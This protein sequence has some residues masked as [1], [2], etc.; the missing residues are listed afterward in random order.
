MSLAAAATAAEMAWSMDEASGTRASS[1]GSH[2]LSDNNTVGSATGQFN[3]AALFVAASSEYL[4]RASGSDVTVGDE[5]ASWSLWFKTPSSFP[6]SNQVLLTRQAG[7]GVN[8]YNLVFQSAFTRLLFS[9]GIAQ[10]VSSV[11]LSTNTW[12]F[13]SFGHDSVNNLVFLRISGHTTDTTSDSGFD[14]FLPI[15]APLRVGTDQFSQFLDGAIDDLVFM[16]GYV[17]TDADHDDAYASGTGV[18]FSSWAGGGVTVTPDV[19]FL[20]L[21]T[22]A[23]VVS[24]PALATPG[25]VSLTL[26]AFAP[27]VSTPTTATPGLAT[28]TLALLAPAVAT[29][30]VVTPGMASL[31]LSAFAPDITVGGNIT[32]VPFKTSL[33]L[34]GRQPALLVNGVPVDTPSDFARNHPSIPPMEGELGRRLQRFSEMV[35]DRFNSL[36]RLGLIRF[37]SPGHWDLAANLHALADL[38]GAADKLAYFT[39]LGTMALTTLTAFGRSLIGAADAAT[40]RGLI[41]AG[42]GSGTVTSITLTQP[43]AG[44][45]ITGSGVAIITT[46]TPTFALANDLA[47]LEALSGTDTIYYR[48][49]VSTWSAVNVSTGLSFTSGTLTAT[50]GGGT[51][52]TTGSP[53]SG[54]LAKFSGTLSVTNGDLS[55]DVATSGTLVTTIGS[56]KVTLAKIANASANSVLVGSG[57][58]GSGAAYVE[59]TL[60]SGLSM[61]GTTLSSTGAG[62]LVLITESTPSSTGV[63]TF[64][65]IPATYR[66]LRVVVRGASTVSA[67]NTDVRITFNNDTSSIYDQ[68]LLSTTGVSNNA[69]SATP[70]AAAANISIGNISGATAASGNGGIVE[71]TVYD[72]RGT[73]FH[74]AVWFNGATKTAD[75][76]T[77]LFPRYGPGFWRSTTAINRVDVT[78]ASG[79]FVAGSV[80]SLYGVF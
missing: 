4:D 12:Y 40:A 79:N 41:G 15:T 67:T 19:A 2:D 72:Y 16:R 56:S 61:T 71:A 51:V 57:A 10:V 25:L 45:T 78:L 20:A 8:N 35:A 18:A 3:N 66:D 42:T 31:L 80:V 59:V 68:Q 70:T 49:G 34:T 46:G 9:Y 37:L 36:G 24:T 13:I 44:F 26:T 38:V 39:G 21:T 5:D 65:S 62:A 63:V 75:A 22:F 28:L 55:G 69:A 77:G 58:S 14:A 76:T 32:V 33:L 60:G 29:P 48:S 7:N 73:T 52:T 54:N 74:K 64:S 47:A 43:A 11:T 30:T 1:I 27:T 53:A 50:G 23:P 17:F 6:G